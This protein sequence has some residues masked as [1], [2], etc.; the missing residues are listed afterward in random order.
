ME[1]L[2]ISLSKCMCISFPEVQIL[3]C[4]DLR[5]TIYLQTPLYGV[6]QLMLHIYEQ[7]SK[8]FER[9]CK[10]MLTIGLSRAFLI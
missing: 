5:F 2:K 3:L 6:L 9:N 7:T 4:G 1:F 8:P 10:M